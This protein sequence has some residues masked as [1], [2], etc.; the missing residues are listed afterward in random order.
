MVV[1][2]TQYIA[3]ELGYFKMLN[4]KFLIGVIVDVKLMNREGAKFDP[5]L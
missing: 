5:S 3:S 1:I 2:W 4:N